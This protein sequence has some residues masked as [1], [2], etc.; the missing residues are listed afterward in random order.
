M[1]LVVGK[2]ALINWDL[3]TMLVSIQINKMT[4]IT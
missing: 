3:E 2:T 1:H 4:I